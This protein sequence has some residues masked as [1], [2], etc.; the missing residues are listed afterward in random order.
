MKAYKCYGVNGKKE[1]ISLIPREGDA[2]PDEVELYLQ[3]YCKEATNKDGVPAIEYNGM[4]Y[5]DRHLIYRRNT[6]SVKKY[7][8]GDEIGHPSGEIIVVATVK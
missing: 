3:P 4:L 1:I 6:I 8:S 7:V 5:F 2:E